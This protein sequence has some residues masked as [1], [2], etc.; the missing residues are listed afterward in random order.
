[1]IEETIFTNRLSALG[2]E[3]DWSQPELGNK[4]GT[5]EAILSRYERGETAGV[6]LDYLVSNTEVANIL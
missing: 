3:G 6:T 4:V 2:K 5:S 1:M